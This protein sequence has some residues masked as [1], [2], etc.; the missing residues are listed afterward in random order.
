MADKIIHLRSL[1]PD[2]VPT[3]SSLGVGQFAINVPDGKIFIRKSGSVSDTIETA[4]TTNAQNSGSVYLT[5]S[6]DVS[7]STKFVGNHTQQG[8]IKL[9]GSIDPATPNGNYIF[10]SR[11]MFHP[12]EDLWFRHHGDTVNYDWHLATME[13][14][15]LYG[16]VVT[17]S[18]NTSLLRRLLA[19]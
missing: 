3:T 1:T 9:T 4:I 12:G 17:F 2:S 6:L 11:S 7:G 18:G 13:T 8:W 5:G 10:S 16:G 14:G 15:L 19:V